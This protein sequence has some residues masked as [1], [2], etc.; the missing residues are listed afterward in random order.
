MEGNTQVYLPGSEKNWSLKYL[1]ST[2][3]HLG[4]TESGKN[5]AFIS[6]SRLKHMPTRT[7]AE[8][9]IVD[10]LKGRNVTTLRRIEKSL[11]EISSVLKKSKTTLRVAAMMPSVN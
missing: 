1:I 8:Q 7:S 9:A 5:G 6:V 4:L 3:I 10:A 11:F 2:Q